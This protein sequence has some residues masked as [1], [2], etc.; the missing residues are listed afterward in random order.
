[1]QAGMA[2]AARREWQNRP[3]AE[4]DC[5]ASRGISVDALVAQGIPPSDPRIRQRIAE[6]RAV[7]APQGQPMQRV[8][9]AQ[10]VLKLTCSPTIGDPTSKD[11]ITSVVVTVSSALIDPSHRFTSGDQFSVVHISAS[12]NRYDRGEQYFISDIS[13]GP[14]ISWTGTLK[15]KPNISMT[16]IIRNIHSSQPAYIET[17]TN[18]ANGQGPKGISANTCMVEADVQPTNQISSGA[19]NAP[20]SY[21]NPPQQGPDPAAIAKDQERQDQERKQRLEKAIASAKQLVEDA[22]GFV[23]TNPNNPK[24]YDY[25]EQIASINSAII[26]NDP[27]AIEQKEAE[28][29]TELNREPAYMKLLA[30]R[31]EEQKQS[32]ARYLGDAVR[33]ATK[34]K[35]FM[36]DYV[37]QNAAS[38]EAIKF[39]ALLKQMEPIL[40]H[41]E[42]PRLEQMNQATDLAIREAG[43]NNSFAAFESVSVPSPSASQSAPP[44]A[45]SNS[46]LPT[47]EKNRFL[48][49][50]DLEDVVMLYN[51][52]P[53]APHIARN[54]RGDLVFSD[55]EANV[56]LLGNNPDGV[57]SIVRSNV[58]TLH[59]RIIGS[60]DRRCDPLKLHDYDIVA[61]QRGAFLSLSAE[62]AL[63]VLGVIEKGEF[64]KLVVVPI[65]AQRAAVEAEKKNISQIATE[66]ADGSRTGFGLLMLKGGSANVCMVVSDKTEALT[67]LLLANADSLSLA[68]HANPTISRSSAEDTF[69]AIRKS[70]CGAVYASATDLKVV[71]E[72]LDRESVPFSFADIWMSSSDI[73][74]ANTALVE[75]RKAAEQEAAERAQKVADQARLEEQRKADQSADTAV[76]ERALQAQYGGSAHAAVALITDDVKA[77]T[78]EQ[79]GVVGKSFPAYAAWLNQH[80]TDHW[81]VMSINSDIADYGTSNFKGRNLDTPVAKVIIKLKNRILGEY[82]DACFLFG[83]VV[84]TEFAMTREP[85]ESSCDDIDAITRWKDGHQFQSRWIVGGTNSARVTKSS[86]SAD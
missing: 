65:A 15:N 49:N 86:V 21:A 17:L 64:E 73:D 12:G 10:Q 25:V 30:A 55:G 53:E 34:Q 71:T 46:P 28:L 72:A 68:M 70:Q 31:A 2:D 4:Y 56:C 59:S 57:A 85:F 38:P 1:M 77:W 41:P 47:T 79:H 69:V 76:Q 8:N 35:R 52:T 27:T 48:M 61:A 13:S 32:N 16:G 50:G 60:P 7:M 3:V 83:R 18:T 63:S 37:S 23:K 11:P 22:S 78:A 80:F 5:L 66:V 36:L 67:H 29:A 45:A 20:S 74:A 9:V 33:L 62:D 24:L 19:G 54:L 75:S 82:E 81:E 84:D 40:T 58:L 6:C 43:L 39:V 42:L 26:G 14:D 44:S 51:S